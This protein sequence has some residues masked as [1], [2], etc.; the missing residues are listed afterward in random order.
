MWSSQALRDPHALEGLSG[1][2]QYLPPVF[3]CSSTT[4][5]TGTGD[6]AAHLHT[7]EEL[8]P[9][10]SESPL[11]PSFL[12]AITCCPPP[13]AQRID[14]GSGGGKGPTQQ[15]QTGPLPT[16]LSWWGATVISVHTQYTEFAW[17]QALQHQVAR[18]ERGRP[19]PGREAPRTTF[20]LLNMAPRGYLGQS[21]ITQ[22]ARSCSVTD[23][24]ACHVYQPYPT[25]AAYQGSKRPQIT[26]VDGYRVRGWIS[27][28]AAINMRFGIPAAILGSLYRALDSGCHARRGGTLQSTALSLCHGATCV[29]GICTLH[30]AFPAR[31][32]TNPVVQLTGIQSDLDYS[33]LPKRNQGTSV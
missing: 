27:G 29:E 6:W 23:P 10:P 7:P 17:G 3:V 28:S 26:F 19:N 12:S 18:E 22:P 32:A 13:V 16:S 5:S 14:W 9:L 8:R 11:T 30:S 20:F 25:R 15:A 2:T 24:S 33:L 1:C 4:R 31:H 21:T